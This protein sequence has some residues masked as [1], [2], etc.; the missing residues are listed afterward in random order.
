MDLRS[1]IFRNGSVIAL[2]LLCIKDIAALTC[3]KNDEDKGLFCRAINTENY[4]VNTKNCAMETCTGKDVCGRKTT[5]KPGSRGNVGFE[6]ADVWLE[7]CVSPDKASGCE[8]VELSETE[9]C[10]CNTD[11]C[12]FADRPTKNLITITLAFVLTLALQFHN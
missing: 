6:L 11:F 2:L 4:N 9:Y 8:D 5:M 7:G 12:N 1:M 10:T 3:W